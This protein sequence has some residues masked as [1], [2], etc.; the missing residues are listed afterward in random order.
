MYNTV[1]PE[2]KEQSAS[3]TLSWLWGTK[4]RKMHKAEQSSDWL[5]LLKYHSI[6][7]HCIELYTLCIFAQA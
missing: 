3:P 4:L 2:R 6:C 7:C 5:R 1:P